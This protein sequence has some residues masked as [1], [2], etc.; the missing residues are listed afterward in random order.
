[1]SDILLAEANNMNAK[2]ERFI[3]QGVYNMLYGTVQLLMVSAEAAKV[4][5]DNDTLSVNRSKV[6]LHIHVTTSFLDILN[7]DGKLE[8]LPCVEL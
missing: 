7:E 6:S 4:T 5:G 2:D 3:S 8:F 1:M